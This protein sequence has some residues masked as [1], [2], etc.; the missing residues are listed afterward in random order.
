MIRK[1]PA[2][3]QPLNEGA[4]VRT[5]RTVTAVATGGASVARRGG[6]AVRGL[7]C[8]F[9]AILWGFTGIGGGL[10]TGNLPMIIGVGAMVAFMLWMGRRSFAK[11][12]KPSG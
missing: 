10:A 12:R 3:W 7:A 4:A 1:P 8:Y 2:D 5:V 11:A 9:F 6:H